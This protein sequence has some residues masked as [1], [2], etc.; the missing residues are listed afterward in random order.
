MV[1]L[2]CGVVL[3]VLAAGAVAAVFGWR[4]R[5]NRVQTVTMSKLIE[6]GEAKGILL[7]ENEV[8]ARLTRQWSLNDKIFFTQFNN[9]PV[10]RVLINSLP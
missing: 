8:T 2:I 5:Q 6:E 7:E 4:R 1:G 9:P 10:D 3:V